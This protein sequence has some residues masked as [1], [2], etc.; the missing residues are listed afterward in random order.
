M[1]KKS[2]NLIFAE[3]TLAHFYLFFAKKIRQN[4]GLVLT[5]DFTK[6]Q[7]VFC[8]DQFAYGLVLVF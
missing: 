5:V 4:D 2:S 3:K 8:L 6:F 7:S 1:E